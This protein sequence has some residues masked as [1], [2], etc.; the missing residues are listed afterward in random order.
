MVA[1]DNTVLYNRPSFVKLDCPD[2]CNQRVYKSKFHS[3][4]LPAGCI[5]NNCVSTVFGASM[6]EFL[7]SK[8]SLFASREINET[9]IRTYLE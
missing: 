2:S 9:S 4:N 6:K 8:L 1:I 7:A 5:Y 3:T